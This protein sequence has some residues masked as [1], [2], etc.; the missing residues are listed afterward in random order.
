LP[1]RSLI[2]LI[3]VDVLG[4]KVESLAVGEYKAGTYTATWVGEKV[5][6]GVYF[7]VLEAN[8]V[9]LTQKMVLLK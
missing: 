9:K 7:C 4:R 1:R 5:S 3:I 6:S 8:G 2:K